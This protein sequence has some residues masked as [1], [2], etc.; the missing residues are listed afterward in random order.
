[1]ADNGAY[2]GLS[3][4]QRRPREPGRPLAP[5]RGEVLERIDFALPRGA[6]IAG[7]VFDAYGDPVAGARVSVVRQRR[8][9]LTPRTWIG[10]DTD[11]L[12]RFRLFGLEPGT[13]LVEATPPQLGASGRSGYV[14]T[15]YP[16]APGAAQATPITLGVGSEH[17][18]A[19]V[20]LVVGTLSQVRG[21]VVEVAPPRAPGLPSSPGSSGGRAQT[22][23]VRRIHPSRCPTP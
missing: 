16:N 1:M 20:V 10:S 21:R 2:V 15:Y 13:Y 18:D 22:R 6:V 5:G 23:P 17:L 19:D 14:T 7:R 9:Q 12:G 11:D 3:Y 8:G 4:G